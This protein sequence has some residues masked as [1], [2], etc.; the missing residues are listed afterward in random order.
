MIYV[1]IYK[2]NMKDLI[3]FNTFK[4]NLIYI[5]VIINNFMGK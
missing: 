3:K 4:I 1:Y 2:D 5:Y